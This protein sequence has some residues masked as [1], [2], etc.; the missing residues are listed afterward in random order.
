MN[1]CLTSPLADTLDRKSPL[2]D[3]VDRPHAADYIGVATSTLALWAHTG[4][5]REL[6]P[7]AR[8]GKKALYRRAD[9][10]RFLAAQFPPA[11]Q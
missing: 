2:A 1:P 9:L 6:L 5:H 7:F 4:K 3:C 10:D 11:N 8:H